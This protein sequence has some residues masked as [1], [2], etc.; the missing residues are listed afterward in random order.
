[1]RTVNRGRAGLFHH[2]LF[3]NCD[4]AAPVMNRAIMILRNYQLRVYR[5]LF[6]VMNS[7]RSGDF[8]DIHPGS[9]LKS[10]AQSD[11]EPEKVAYWIEPAFGSLRQRRP[12]PPPG[13]GAVRPGT[14]ESSAPYSYKSCSQC[15]L[16]MRDMATGQLAS[17]FSSF[18]QI[19]HSNKSSLKKWPN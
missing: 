19:I 15:S 5:K 3:E 18:K 6:V 17:F 8:R 4:S 2:T 12:R 13:R 16:S 14:A 9:S 7:D 10:F 11:S 1:V